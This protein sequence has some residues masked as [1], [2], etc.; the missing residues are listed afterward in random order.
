VTTFEACRCGC[1]KPIPARLLA[2]RLDCIFVVALE[3]GEIGPDLFHATCRMGL[4]ALL[5]KRRD[6]SY[7][8]GRSKHWI[9]VK[10]REHL[11]MSRVM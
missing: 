8:S 6:R 7:Q 10:N 2:R 3:Q 4:E 11:A 1:A 5:S 9:N